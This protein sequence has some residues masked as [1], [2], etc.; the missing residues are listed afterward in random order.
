MDFCRQDVMLILA[1]AAVGV[2]M[3]IFYLRYEELQVEITNSNTLNVM[4]N[5]V[6]NIEKK[7]EGISFTY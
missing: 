3:G 7:L 5:R 2:L 6:E 4:S 1:G